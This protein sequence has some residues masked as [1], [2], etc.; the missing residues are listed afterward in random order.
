MSLI[1]GADAS[2]VSSSS[3]GTRVYALQLLQALL[4]ARPQWQFILYLRTENEAQALGDLRSFAQIKTRVVQG[5]PNVWRVQ[6][7]LPHY[8]D[9]D[10][11]DVYHSFGYFL[12]L[13]W[14]GPKVVTVHDLNFYFAAR[15]WMRR[16]TV[17]SWLDLA[18]QTGLSVRMADMV[19][20]DSNSSRG[21]IRQLLW[22]PDQRIRVIPLA[23]DPFFNEMPQLGELHAAAELVAGR[24]FVLFVGIL[25]PQKNLLTLVRAFAGSGLAKSGVKLLLVGSD[26]ENYGA[27]LRS[28]SSKLGV[29]DSVVLAGYV[30]PSILRAC[31]R[32]ALCLVLPSQ[33]EGFGLPLVE[34]MASGVPMLA[35]NRQAIPEVLGTSGYLYDADDSHCLSNLLTRVGKDGSFRRELA[36]NARAGARRYSW[37]STAE[38]TAA[39]Y[40]E[41]AAAKRR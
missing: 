3:G 35:A 4:V 22:L 18:M 9:R 26:R 7:L 2:V 25:S 12:P 37:H 29:T 32:T 21:Q 27:T 15:N 36:Q 24:P 41:A 28:E 10:K 11:V 30:A 34:G 31:Y 1:I 13:R 33:G 39:V 17:L 16:Q 23:A 5:R 40:E 20:T 14:G 38:A 19:I 8:L 6:G